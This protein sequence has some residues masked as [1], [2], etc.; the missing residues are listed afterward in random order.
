[1]I[2]EKLNKVIKRHSLK[3]EINEMIADTVCDRKMTPDAEA[4]ADVLVKKRD[5]APSAKQI[6]PDETKC[7]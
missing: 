4:A 2:F 5:T 3:D 6:K 1:M 7:R